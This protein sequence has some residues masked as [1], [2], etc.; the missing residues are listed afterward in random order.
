MAD[1]LNV[2][3]DGRIVYTDFLMENYQGVFHS[4]EYDRNDRFSAYNALV[5]SYHNGANNKDVKQ[6]SE[7]WNFTNE[8]SKIYADKIGIDITEDSNGFKAKWKNLEGKETLP[9]KSV[10]EAIL[11]LTFR[12]KT[13][14]EE[15]IYSDTNKPIKEF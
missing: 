9:K 4:V 11:N 3:K 13:I 5:R 7:E 14:F 2:L 8:D 10:F 12:Y 1:F 15:N 6:L